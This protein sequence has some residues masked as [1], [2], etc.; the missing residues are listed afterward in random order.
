[1][2]DDTNIPKLIK[3][4]YVV[5]LVCNEDS[6]IRSY[7]GTLKECAEHITYLKNWQTSMADHLNKNG[8]DKCIPA[9]NCHC[10]WRKSKQNLQILTQSEFDKRIAE[11][12]KKH[13]NIIT[14]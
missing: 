4:N 1:M 13:P 8:H 9:D 5:I 14:V 11:F 10:A 7:T 12:M 3:N 6:F 2:S